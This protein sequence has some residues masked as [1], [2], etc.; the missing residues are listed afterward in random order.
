[1]DVVVEG[2]GDDGGINEGVV[3][4]AAVN[5]VN[6]LPNVNLLRAHC[7]IVKSCYFNINTCI[8]QCYFNL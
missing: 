4:Q 2:T 1:M 6:N 7:Y 3:N 5:E 8:D